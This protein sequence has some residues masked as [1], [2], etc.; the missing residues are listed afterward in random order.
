MVEHHPDRAFAGVGC[1]I[2]A[3]LRHRSILSRNGAFD[4]PVA[5]RSLST[6]KAA[7]E[8]LN[9]RRLFTTSFNR[10]HASRRD[11]GQAVSTDPGMEVAML[12]ESPR[13]QERGAY[14]APPALWREPAEGRR[15]SPPASGSPAPR[16]GAATGPDRPV[17]YVV[18]G[19][20]ATREAL[21]GLVASAGWRAETFG[22]ARDF[23]AR[24]RPPVPSCLVLNLRLPDCCGL[25]LQRRLAR[26]RGETPVI[27]V[28]EAGDV[29]TTVRA[30]KAG[31]V[32]FLVKP[33]ADD[34]ILGAMGQALGRSRG[35][36]ALETERRPL[37]ARHSSL[38][39]RERQVM[40]LVVSGL[41]NKQVG[42]ELGIS[43]ITVKAHRGR[44]MRKMGAASLA[45][46]V[47]MA[48]MLGD[49]VQGQ[50]SPRAN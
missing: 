36:L 37:R 31:A 18:D 2:R 24:P 8:E 46:L 13:T 9:H 32:E 48:A 4:K 45:D 30:M 21:E 20:A 19:D 39:L 27:F 44:V 40:A 49:A 34:Q 33:F 47:T 15:G 10:Q 43:E 3:S 23:L 42:F 5:V 28:T 16:G 26:E 25:D 22:R 1:V 12:R 17:V 41:L 7:P 50:R 38:S 6:V 35:A 14:L 11:R 29:E